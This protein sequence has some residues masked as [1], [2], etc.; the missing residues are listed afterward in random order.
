MVKAVIYARYSSDK[1]DESSIDAQAR[2]CEAYA[3]AH[4]YI[5]VKRYYDEAI[6][7]KGSKTA[8]RREYQRMIKDAENRLFDVVLIHKYDRIARNLREHANLEKRLT[9]NN[10]SLIAAAQ[11]F[12]FTSEAK[13]LK[14]MLWAMSEYYIDN[15]SSEVKKGHKE[16]ALKAL[17]NGGYAPFGYDVVDQKYYINEIESAYV[18]KI[19]DCALN[20]VGYT[21]LIKEMKLAGITGKRGKPIT[22]NAIYEILRNEKYTGTYVFC[23]SMGGT[24][25]ERR[26]KKDAIKIENALPIIISKAKFDEVQNIMKY[27]K[28]TGRK[29][30]Y[31]CSGLVYCGNCGAKMHG[32]TTHRKGHEYRKYFCSAKCGIGTIDMDFIDRSALEYINDL[33]D[34]NN[35]IALT[36]AL[37]SFI[38]GEKFR[39]KEFNNSI[40]NQIEQRTEKINNY[41]NTLGSGALPPEVISDVGSKIV[42]LKEEI[43]TLESAEPPQD[44]S[45]LQIKDWVT[46][47]RNA[48][49]DKAV[50]LLIGRINA[51]KTETTMQ[52][53][54]DSVLGKT[55]R[56]DRI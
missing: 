56:G 14:S 42:K 49:D 11:D 19:F 41:M 45:V 1:Q 35:L 15:L 13:I 39:V 50:K 21:N 22:Y 9:D 33:L 38:A 24:R 40:K 32:G 4:G 51:T 47:I 23:Q 27:R 5:I 12:G 52:S 20:R 3:M 18:K 6:S 55:G 34:D 16:T 8:L 28:Q 29:A 48:P 46:A 2:A 30:G 44:F 36:G 26:A 54:L 17:H 43:K 37:S 53:T 10:V 7:G 31:L 25:E